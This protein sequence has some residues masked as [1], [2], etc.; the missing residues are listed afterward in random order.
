MENVKKR[1][2]APRRR[3]TKAALSPSFITAFYFSIAT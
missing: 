3:R 1:E 2:V